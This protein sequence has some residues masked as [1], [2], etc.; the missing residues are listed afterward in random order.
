VSALAVAETKASCSDSSA[1]ARDRLNPVAARQTRKNSLQ[2][3]ESITGNTP[4]RASNPLRSLVP[5]QKTGGR[6][7]RS[8]ALTLNSRNSCSKYKERRRDQQLARARGV[9]TS[10]DSVVHALLVP[11]FH[12]STLRD[13]MLRE[14]MLC[15]F[16]NRCFVESALDDSMHTSLRFPTQSRDGKNRYR[17]NTG[18]EPVQPIFRS[19]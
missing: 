4:T 13:S 15:A 10:L 5:N 1:F 7:S 8:L 6:P 9:V 14:S 17:G 16:A 18:S 3:I 12:R 11:C 2:T 19:G